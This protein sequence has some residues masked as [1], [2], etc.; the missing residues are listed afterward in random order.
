M[1]LPND[2]LSGILQLNNG[3]WEFNQQLMKG[4]ELGSD[5]DVIVWEFDTN[6]VNDCFEFLGLLGV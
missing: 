5:V 1:R 4:V 6:R 3:I 2:F